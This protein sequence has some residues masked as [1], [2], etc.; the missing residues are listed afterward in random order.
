MKIFLDPGHGGFD[1][2]AVNTST[3]LKESDVNLD[4]ALEL[5]KLLESNGYLI[6]YSRTTDEPV[7]LD[8][9]A[10]MAN[11]WSANYFVSIHCNSSVV[12]TAK[13]TETFFYRE[14]ITSEKLAKVV[15]NELVD[16]IKTK[17]R[18]TSIANFAVLRL[19]FMPSILVELA[20]ISN[21]EEAALL[22]TKDFR[23]KC[24]KGIENGLVKFIDSVL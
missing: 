21:N 11:E 23:N 22:A 6:K 16:Q 15:Q 5:G 14:G 17:D 8:T 12:E 9:R 4:V 19:S 3:G 2:G 18:G 1:P 13:G 7:S 10:N 24:A 20:F